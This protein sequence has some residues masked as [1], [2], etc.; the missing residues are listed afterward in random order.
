M[1]EATLSAPWFP[2]VC[3]VSVSVDSPSLVSTAAVT[4]ILAELIADAMPESVLTPLP[5]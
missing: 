1:L 5:V 4:P 3:E 2:A